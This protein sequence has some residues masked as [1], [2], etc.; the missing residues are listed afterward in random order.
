M[1]SDTA[2]SAACAFRSVCLLL[3]SASR[4]NIRTTVLSVEKTCSLPVSLLKI[5]PAVTPFMRT[6][7][8]SWLGLIIVVPSARRRLS[9]SNPWPLLGRHEP[10]TL[11]SIRCPVI[12]KELSTSCA[13]IAE[14]RAPVGTG[15]SW[16]SN[17][18]VVTP[19]TR[20]WSR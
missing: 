9:H 5:Y 10:G 17:V 14:R 20:L 18:P 3:I 8:G 1:L 19:S 7:S 13:M 6:V 12:C 15:T 4:I 2:M 11:Q 16:G